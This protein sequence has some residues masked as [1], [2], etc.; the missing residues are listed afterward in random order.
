MQI[1]YRKAQSTSKGARGTNWSWTW[2]RVQFVWPGFA[3]RWRANR[4]LPRRFRVDPQS[5]RLCLQIHLGFFF[6]I[7]VVSD[8]STYF[9]RVFLWVWGFFGRCVWIRRWVWFICIIVMQMKLGLWFLICI[10]WAWSSFLSAFLTIFFFHKLRPLPRWL[11]QT[12]TLHHADHH[13]PRDVIWDLWC[14]DLWVWFLILFFFSF[15]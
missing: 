14:F 5:T 6:P 9:D 4:V 3:P 15:S 13:N 8:P 7:W 10:R 2:I 11:P 12:H 1:R